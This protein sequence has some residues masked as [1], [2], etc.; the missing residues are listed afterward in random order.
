ML[1]HVI[2]ACITEENYYWFFIDYGLLQFTT[3]FW[4]CRSFKFSRKTAL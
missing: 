1:I 4:K 3:F 2:F